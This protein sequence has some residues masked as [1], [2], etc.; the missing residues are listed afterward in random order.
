MNAILFVFSI[1]FILQ[2]AKCEADSEAIIRTVNSKN[3]S[4]KAGYNARFHNADDEFVR[5]HLGAQL[6]SD[7]ELEEF[8]GRKWPQTDLDSLPDEFDLREQYPDC[9]TIQEVRDQGACG[10]CWVS[11]ELRILIGNVCEI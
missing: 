10:S 2:V 4:W 11:S 5:M 6:M 8:G 1:Y 9:K 3:R 7:A